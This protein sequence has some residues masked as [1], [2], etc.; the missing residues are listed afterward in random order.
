M[1]SFIGNMFRAANSKIDPTLA[2]KL[3]TWYLRSV[4]D[5][6]VNRASELV[7]NM[8]RGFDRVGFKD[9]LMK[10]GGITSSDADRIIAAL[11][12]PAKGEDT[13]ALNS[14]LKRRS[15]LDE[16]YSETVQLANGSNA[17][18][19]YKDL[20]DTD[21]VGM[22]NNYFTK[23]AGSIA[24]ANHTGLYR[25]NDV[26]K[27]IAEITARD[28][29][30]EMTTEQLTKMR[31]HLKDIVDLTLGRPLEDFSTVNK[32]LQ[33]V[34][35]YNVLTKAGLFVL[36][37]ITEMAQLM[38]SPM[39]RGVLKSVPEL[40][41][42]IRSTK[43]GKV[44]NEVIDALEN[45]SAGPGTQLLRDNPL[46]PERQWVREKGDTKFNQWLDSADNLLKRG[47]HNLFKYT[48]M[49]PVMMMQQ[50]TLAVAFVNHLVDHAVN[51]KKLGYSADRLAWMG[52]DATDSAEVMAKIKQYHKSQGKSR[53][54]TVDFNKWSQDDPKSFS[55][56]IV[57]YQR[58]SARVIQEND[59]ASMVPIMGKQVGRTVFQFMGFPLQ[60]W[61][62]SMLF[63][64]NHK[65]I[66][67]LNTVMWA[68]GF[69]AMMYV[70]RTQLQ[71]AGMS[72]VEAQ[73]LAEKRLS[74]QQ[75]MLNA[76][77]RVPQ[78]SVVPNIFDT[79]SPVPLFSGMRT[80]TDM[81]DFV[82][83]N[84]TLSTVSSALSSAKKV[85]RNT[86][87]EDYQTTER[88]V[89]KMFQLMPLNNVMG[90]SNFVN[91]V[92]ADYPSSEQVSE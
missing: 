87:S 4:E 31:K 26:N 82:S 60:A 55:K 37:Q 8:L 13:G 71:M 42:M 69:N 70:A 53:L 92:A 77:G 43:S 54:G 51:G 12:K 46:T 86:A 65:D 25:I 90:I 81:T 27:V 30:S 7:D 76:V 11:G 48:G 2:K 85:V 59:L 28:F 35:D 44:D 23:Q 50:R 83:G 62:K 78:L 39:W 10:V 22:I 64:M 66:S 17:T 16:T 41:S 79:V 49:T 89:K 57:A 15:I 58:E 3:G 84:P 34:A 19:S 6:K 33:M 80:S 67:T 29:N 63:A 40:G 68:I 24:L 74:T 91:S 18:L 47:T 9:S 5:A 75:I 14:S 45:L 21:T 61:N 52:M 20:F 73:E 36:N 1:E 72:S 32:S 88:D 38:G 56:F